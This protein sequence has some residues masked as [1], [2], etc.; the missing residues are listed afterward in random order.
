MVS[1]SVNWLRQV[2][3]GDALDLPPVRSCAWYYVEVRWELNKM[4]N[5]CIC[6][7]PDFRATLS[8][9]CDRHW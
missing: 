4:V 5:K 7:S 3:F 2:S 6:L 9:W 8:S 1:L